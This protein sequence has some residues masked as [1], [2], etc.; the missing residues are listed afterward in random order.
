V[1]FHVETAE[2][3]SRTYTVEADDEEQARKRMRLHFSD[4]GAL[5]PGLV[6]GPRNE[7]PKSRIIRAIA[8]QIDAP[9]SD[10]EQA[11]EETGGTPTV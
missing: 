5:A 6:V 8:V 4:P 2:H 7:R 11:G 9:G 1:K 10:N 3:T